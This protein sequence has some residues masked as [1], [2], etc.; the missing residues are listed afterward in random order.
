MR[1]P[2]QLEERARA[3]VF[4]GQWSP[5]QARPAATVVLLRDNSGLEVALLQRAKTLAFAHSMYV[6]PGGAV[7]AGDA[8]LGDP[9]LVAAIRETFEE[10]GVLLTRPAPPQAARSRREQ[11]FAQLLAE[12]ELVPDEAAL[13]PFAHWVTP[14]VESRRFDTRF[15]AAALPAGQDLAE[16]TGEHQNI[17]WYRPAEAAGLPMLPPTAAVLAEL[18]GFA[19]VADVLAVTRKPQPIMPHPV[20]QGD[21]IAWVLIN[22]ETGAAL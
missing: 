5:P 11:P 14:E 19:T 8:A 13:A 21:D 22:A 2:P 4:G 17:G 12:F 16:F 7:D 18:A 20:A 1:M 6:F 15:Y 3:I 10:A 9:W